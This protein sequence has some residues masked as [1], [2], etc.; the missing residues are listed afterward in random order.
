LGCLT[1]SPTSL[2]NWRVTE[3]Y[4]NNHSQY[5][6]LSPR[7]LRLL[8]EKRRFERPAN[9]RQGDGEYTCSPESYYWSQLLV[10]GFTFMFRGSPQ[11]IPTQGIIQIELYPTQAPKT[12][13]NFVSL[14]NAHF[15]D[16]LVWHRVMKGFVIQ[17]G[18]PTTK[19][20]GGDNSTWGNTGSS[21]TIPLETDPSL[22]NYAGYIAMARTSD[23]NSASSQFFINLVDNSGNLDPNPSQNNY[24]YA[25]FGKVTSTSG[26]DV[27]LAIGNLPTNGPNP[28]PGTGQA[29]EPLKPYPLVTSITITG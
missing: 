18:D 27:A 5:V 13:N 12:V 2:S 16:G 10:S 1:Q 7:C 24:G 11:T 8:R 25:V 26:M 21:Q 6:I 19:N 3:S 15:Y 29:N 9:R 23:R 22:H 14:V 20:G 17:T 28:A 4:F